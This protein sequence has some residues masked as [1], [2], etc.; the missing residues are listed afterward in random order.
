[1]NFTGMVGDLQQALATDIAQIMILL[2][3][4]PA[5]AYARIVE[6]GKSVG[7]KYGVNLV[8]NFP[9]REQINDYAS[10]GHRDISIIID[11][12]KTRFPIPREQIKAEAASRIPGARTEDAY[13]Y[14]GKEGVKVFHDGGRIDILPHSLHV[15]CMF[16][17]EVCSYC[18]WLMDNVYSGSRV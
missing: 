15:W 10:Y 7:A 9:K 4:S 2:K 14:E 16:T 1:M 17:P 5:T 11:R 18:G 12:E 3:Q 6:I 8:V 13:M